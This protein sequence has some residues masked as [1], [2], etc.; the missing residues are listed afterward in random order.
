MQKCLSHF[1]GATTTRVQRLGCIAD[2]MRRWNPRSMRARKIY[3]RTKTWRIVR[4]LYCEKLNEREKKLQTLQSLLTA[5]RWPRASEG[6]NFDETALCEWQ[7]VQNRDVNKFHACST[8]YSL[9]CSM[10]VKKKMRCT[11][12]L[13]ILRN[14]AS[15]K[16]IRLRRV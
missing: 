13:M 8:S 10:K 4:N 11:T 15:N 16:R 5:L 6:E 12:G 14:G 2:H 1:N 9:L 7:L 3:V